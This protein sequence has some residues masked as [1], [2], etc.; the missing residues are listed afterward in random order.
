MNN[1]YLSARS[2][3]WTPIML[4]LIAAIAI[5]A[6]ALAC[7]A[8]S[9]ATPD[10]DGESLMAPELGAVAF[11]VAG[12]SIFGPEEGPG[13]D[14]VAL[15]HGYFVED[16]QPIE[17][18]ICG[19]HSGPGGEYHYHFDANCIHWHP[20]TDAGTGGAADALWAEYQQEK[21]D[22]TA[23]SGVIG[24]AFDGYPIYGV[25]ERDE[26]GAVRQVTSNYRLKDGADG[27]NGIDDWEYV[28]G[29]G[30]LDECNGHTSA[31]PRSDA[32][33]YHYHSTWQ[34][35]EGE[36]GFPYFIHC[37]HGEVDEANIPRGGMGPPPGGAGGPPRPPGGPGR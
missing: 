19:G 9:D 16:R 26:S 11:T 30:D 2:R 29:L 3:R 36:I 35:G 20:P 8:E 23:P 27:Y 31:T 10:T 1:N 15:H 13:G 32:P 5:F 4:S 25:Y 33:I 18:G 22:A 28:P 24:F 12:V 34:N 7:G 14:A 17:L 6:L 21:I 37:Y